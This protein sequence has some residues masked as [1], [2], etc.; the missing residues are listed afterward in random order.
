MSENLNASAD[1]SAS[2]EETDSELSAFRQVVEWLA[3]RNSFAI[4]GVFLALGLTAD[5]FGVPEPADNILYL[6]GGV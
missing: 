2:A 3:N 4:V 5:H 6:I 1:R